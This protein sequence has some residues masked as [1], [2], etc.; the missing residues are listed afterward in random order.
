MDI[1]AAYRE[2]GSYRGAAVVCGTTHKTVKR[3]VQ[4]HNAGGA[5]P[6]R[7]GRGH[8]YDQVRALVAEQ[9]AKTHGRISAK[10]LL[11]AARTAGY[12]GSA[13]NFRRL[14]ASAKTTWRRGNHRGRR[15]AVWTPGDTVVIDWGVRD[16][17]H[18]FCAVL[19]SSRIRFVR[20]AADEKASTTLGLLAEC[21]EVFG[22]VPKTVL[23]DRMGSLKAGVVADVVVPTADYVR[24][25]THVGFR[26]WFAPDFAIEILVGIRQHRAGSPTDRG[27]SDHVRVQSWGPTV[28]AGVRSGS[29]PSP[30]STRSGCSW[31]VRR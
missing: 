14:V 2:V 23:A 21:F 22:G 10:R 16:G 4:R 26:P 24:F 17:V 12:Q 25:A 15:P 7:K 8:N 6:E 20:F 29:C 5:G 1:L 18:V 3:V 9:V 27:G 30:R 19:A 31:S 11:P 13:R 28:R